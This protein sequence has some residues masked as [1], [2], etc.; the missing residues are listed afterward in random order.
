MNN[1]L[2]EEMKK[3]L[4]EEL[5]EKELEENKLYQFLNKH[6]NALVQEIKLFPSQARRRFMEITKGEK[7]EDKLYLVGSESQL[8]AALKNMKDYDPDRTVVL[9]QNTSGV[10]IFDSLYSEVLDT[11]N[12]YDLY[13]SSTKV[14]IKF[15][16]FNAKQ[17]KKRIELKT[18]DNTSSQGSLHSL[19]D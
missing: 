7:G 15:D 6:A 16:R 10:H 12:L 14:S 9:L 4:E 13:G 19:F 3:R 1:Q 5:A 8:D 18:F 17:M 11:D 2:K